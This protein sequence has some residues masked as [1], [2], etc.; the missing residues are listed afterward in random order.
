MLPL[1]NIETIHKIP[2]KTFSIQSGWK[3]PGIQNSERKDLELSLFLTPF[4]KDRRQHF[5]W[6]GEVFIFMC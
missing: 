3:R 4:T 1:S 5:R 6:K 2:K